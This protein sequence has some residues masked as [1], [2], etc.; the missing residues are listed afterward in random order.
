MHIDS[1]GR[2]RAKHPAAAYPV[3]RPF[4]EAFGRITL[5]ARV[6]EVGVDDSGVI[7]EGDG[8][9]VERLPYYVGLRSTPLGMLRVRRRLRNIGTR[10]D[11][12]V[13]RVPELVSLAVLA[14]AR[15]AG[16]R[17]LAILAADPQTLQSLAPRP[18]GPLI[19]ALWTW[20]SRRAVRSADAVSYVSE[21][22][23]QSKYPARSGAPTIGRS[24]VILPDGWIKDGP[25]RR[26]QR[27][28]IRL[29]TIGALDHKV[30]GMDFLL[31]VMASLAEEGLSATL[32]IIGDGV[33]RTELEKDANERGL[34]V[35]FAGQV[36]EKAR[37]RNLLDAADVYVSGSRSEGLPRATIE[38]MARSLPVVTTDAGAAGE[39][40]GTPF[41]TQIDKRDAFSRAIYLLASDSEEYQLQ[42]R[43]SLEVSVR[44]SD[45]ASP[46][47]FAA[48][49]RK[50]FMGDWVD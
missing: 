10:D 7:V 20:L 29:I 41:L 28:R 49:L 9:R 8:V 18:F 39:L 47:R 15:S 2:I 30:K 48:F 1:D 42:S 4:V 3:W 22:Y 45:A 21:R 17:N 44:V 25:R 14:R 11:V 43:R 33:L 23:F 16:A 35:N 34:D 32:T 13:G 19:A 46:D 26:T 31:D 6:D 5:L 24:N 36:Q 38:A 12:F 40:V 50:N 27:D 37:I